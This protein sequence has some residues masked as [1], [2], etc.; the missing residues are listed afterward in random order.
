[1]LKVSCHDKT[2]DSYING[3]GMSCLKLLLFITAIPNKKPKVFVPGANPLYPSPIFV[4]KT[5]RFP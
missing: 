5:R 2:R 3:K 4:C 1:M